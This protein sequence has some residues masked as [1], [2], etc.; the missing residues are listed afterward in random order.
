MLLQPQNQEQ[1][2]FDMIRTG[3]DTVCRQARHVRLREDRIAAYADGLRKLDER[4]VFDGKHHFSGTME[5]TACYVLALDCMNFG[6]GYDMLLVEEG[7]EQVDHSL[8]YTISTRLKHYFDENGA[9]RA[10]D[11][12]EI[13]PRQCAAILGLDEK[14]TFSFDFARQCALSLRGMGTKIMADHGGS[15]HDFVDSMQGAADRMVRAL[16]QMPGFD[17]SHNYHGAKICFFKRAQ[18]TAADLHL[19]Y[20]RMGVDLFHDIN[21]LT[22]FPDN[23]V[24][25]VLRTDG[26]LDYMPPL[27]EKIERGVELPSGSE[28]EIEIRA[29]AGKAVELI[30]LHKGMIAMDVDHILWHR[31][32]D[33]PLYRD[34]PTHRTL[35][36]FY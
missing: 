8:Y 30:A 13:S 21:H 36:V 31:G 27:A 35:S 2:V 34:K 15:F 1:S 23:A 22:M 18:I 7:W 20:G 12:A 4:Q 9:M 16:V 17:D 32:T 29:C 10:A 28:E 11:M 24:P 26:I 19:A 3:F 6:S 33:N 25:H 5:D 14:G